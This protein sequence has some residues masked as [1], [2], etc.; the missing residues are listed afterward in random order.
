MR[1]LPGKALQPGSPDSL[2]RSLPSVLHQ[3]TSQ[4]DLR[5]PDLVDNFSGKQD[6][7]NITTGGIDANSGAAGP[8]QSHH[9]TCEHWETLQQKHRLQLHG[10]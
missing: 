10:A 8:H 6:P 3:R 5:M 2:P 4:L 9:R 1:S 7:P